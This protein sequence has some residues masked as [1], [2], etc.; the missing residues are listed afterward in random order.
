MKK[1]TRDLL[2]QVLSNT[3]WRV[4]VNSSAF[5]DEDEFVAFLE[6][7]GG[8]ELFRAYGGTLTEALRVLEGEIRTTF[9]VQ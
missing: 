4:R 6:T 1:N 9:M 7:E 5:G 2:E 8:S 3:D